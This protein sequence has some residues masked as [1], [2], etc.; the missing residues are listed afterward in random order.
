MTNDRPENTEEP[1]P[2]SFAE[3][4]LEFERSMRESHT[5]AD[6]EKNGRCNHAFN[7]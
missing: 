7:D 4:F 2:D 5:C 6:K 1:V 3:G